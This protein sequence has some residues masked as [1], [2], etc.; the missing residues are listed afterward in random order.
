MGEL[1][2]TDFYAAVLL[3]L[4]EF[5]VVGVGFSTRFS[6]GGGITNFLV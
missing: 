6:G 5:S 4:S 1:Q 3:V 2:R